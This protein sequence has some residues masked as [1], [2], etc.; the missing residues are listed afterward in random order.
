MSASSNSS[1]PKTTSTPPRLASPVLSSDVK[2]DGRLPVTILSGFLGSGKTTLLE[3][4]L[5]DKNHGLKIAVIVNDMGA[6]NIDASLVSSVVQKKETIVSM[7][8]GCICCT[9]RGDLLEEVAKLAE[10]KQFDYLVIES[11]GISE[12]QQVAET[13]CLASRCFSS[14]QVTEI[15]LEQF[16]P[17]FADMHLQAAE[18][19]RADAAEKAKQNGQEASVESESQLKLASILADGGLPKIAR[20]DTMVTVVDALNVFNSFNTADF[21]S[22]RQAPETIEEEDERNISDLMVDQLEFADAIII[23]KCDL[24]SKQ[25]LQKIKALV[26]TLNPE[27]TVLTSVRSKIDLRKILNTGK[28]SFEKSMMSAG[29]LKSLREETR[30]ETEEYGIGSFVYR[31]RRP[32]HP[33]RLW[34]CIK[35]RLVVIQ[36]SYEPNEDGMEVDEEADAS[37]ENSWESEP[38]LEAQPQL[39]PVA[40]LASKK[41]SSSFGPLLRSKGFFWLATRPLMSGEWS[42]AGVMLTIGGGS[43]WLCETDETQWPDHPEVRKKM[44]ADFQGRWGDRRQ[45]IVF[46]GET[47]S[48]IQ[49]LLTAELDAALLNDSEWA[50]WEKVMKSKKSSMEK[51]VEKLEKMF[52]DGFEDWIDEE[53]HSGHDHA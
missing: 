24:V 53:D 39:D 21:L 4:I 47:I 6:V 33:F 50:A 2:N 27:C 44:K 7:E 3:Y 30:P 49:P 29:W 42:Q 1:S 37:S 11:T 23:N 34:E 17:E 32:F 12:P 36:D 48:V 9:L 26:K 15:T 25:D 35:D 5:K 51:K 45:E 16:A 19:L 10:Q 41:A 38:D 20:L 31:A 40:R 46:I 14:G 43:R 13:V 22:D 8:N 52:E 28:F 18:D